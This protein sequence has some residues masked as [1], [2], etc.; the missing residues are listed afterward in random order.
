VGT[1]GI[2]E[3]SKDQ[4]CSHSMLNHNIKSFLLSMLKVLALL[5]NFEC[6]LNSLGCYHPT[7]FCFLVLWLN[8]LCKER[9]LVMPSCPVI[10][11]H[12][13]RPGSGS[14]EVV[15]SVGCG[16]YQQPPH[17][18]GPSDLTQVSGDGEQ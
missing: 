11:S 9:W 10:L 4:T 16:G 13:F 2:T 3:G 18:T 7:M 5:S 15:P 1:N 6:M 8:L 14:R 17:A 12:I